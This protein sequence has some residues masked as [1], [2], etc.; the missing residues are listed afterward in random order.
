MRRLGRR[1][2][3]EAHRREFVEGLYAVAEWRMMKGKEMDGQDIINATFKLDEGQ[4]IPVGS[5]VLD[6]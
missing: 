4:Y 6:S 2:C 3:V 1:W 5:F